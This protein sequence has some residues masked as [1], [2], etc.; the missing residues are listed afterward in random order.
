MPWKE[1]DPML[2]RT[3]FIAAY[4]SQVYSM[5]ELCERFGIRRHTGY[6]WVRR[7]TEQGLAGLQEQSRAPPRCP[8]RMSA[9]VEAVLLEAK[10][11]HL[12]WGPRTI[13]PDL[14][15]R[16][17]DLA[18]PAPS[19]AGE[20]FQREGLSQTRKRRRGHRHPGATPL[21][22]AAPHAVWTADFKGQC[23]TGDGLYCYP[24]TGADAYRRF[25]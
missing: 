4:L 23:R 1:T 10:R 16:R 14:A 8:H 20:R 18:L 25:L 5:T 2:E 21:Q 9:A 24:W 17:P 3:Q 7:D 15:R 11:A 19:T 12:H 6:K 13:L 22:A